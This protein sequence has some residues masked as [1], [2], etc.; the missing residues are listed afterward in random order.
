MLSDRLEKS[1][2]KVR[3]ELD[4]NFSWI[5]NETVPWKEPDKPLSE[6]R[7]AYITSCGLYR[8]D[9]QI[10]FNA[11]DNLGDPSFREI[12]VDTPSER[13]RV[14]HSHY[15]HEFVDEDLSV[16]LPFSHF[17]QIEKEGRI[18]TFYPW[19][20]SFMGYLPEPKQFL[21]E[22]VPTIARRLKQDEVNAVLF[23]PC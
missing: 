18:G 19:I 15:R 2:A 23:T 7:L 3:R 14:A 13:L 6:S 12:H 22:T 11:W 20:Y 17:Q 9:S 4:P 16:V 21:E 8:V 1:Q 10:P 5:V